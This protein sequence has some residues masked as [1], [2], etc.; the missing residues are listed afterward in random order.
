VADAYLFTVLSWT[1]HL[2]MDLGQWPALKA[3]VE[4]MGARPA[5]REALK[6]EGLIKG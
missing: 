3:F 6:A 1:P 5:V 2:G 4:R